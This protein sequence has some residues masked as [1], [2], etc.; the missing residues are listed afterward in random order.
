MPPKAVVDLEESSSPVWTV[1]FVIA[2]LMAALIGY[3][4]Y[5]NQQRAKLLGTEKKKKLSAKKAAKEARVNR[6]QFSM[7]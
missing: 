3:V 6:S 2:V 1:L 5:V 7:E 4:V